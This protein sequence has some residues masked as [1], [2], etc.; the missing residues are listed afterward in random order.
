M[1][2]YEGKDVAVLGWESVRLRF[3]ASEVGPL[4]VWFDSRGVVTSVVLLEL[5]PLDKPDRIQLS[6]AHW[7]LDVIDR[8][9]LSY[10]RERVEEMLK[11]VKLFGG[12]LIVSND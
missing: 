10:V 9:L 12:S 1:F 5:Q 4:E 3:W 8:E 6:K 2:S 7:R 11:Y